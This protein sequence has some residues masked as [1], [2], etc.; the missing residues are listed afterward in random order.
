MQVNAAEST[1]TQVTYTFGTDSAG[2]ATQNL[3]I[4][5]FDAG[6]AGDILNL[7]GLAVAANDTVVARL[8]ATTGATLGAA[9]VAAANINEMIIGA[10]AAAQ[11]NGALTA[12]TDAGAVEAAII[13]L[14]LVAADDTA[15]NIYITLDNGTDT[16]V[17]RVTLD[18]AGNTLI[19][20]AAEITSVVLVATLQGISDVNAFTAFN[21]A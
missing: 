20:T 15:T 5:G 10:T 21:F 1:A 12:T 11:I 17:Y 2:G 3:R 6:A 4:S 13:A 14:G 18:G 9:G 16:G 7:G 19:D 8:V